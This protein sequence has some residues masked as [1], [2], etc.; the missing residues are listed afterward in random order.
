VL[1][2]ERE[3]SGRVFGATFPILHCSWTKRAYTHMGRTDLITKAKRG[4]KQLPNYH[5][6][7]LAIAEMGDHHNRRVYC[8][9]M[10]G[11]FE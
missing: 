5:V 4:L 6:A 8:C 7:R 2:V 3:P 9:D 10:V 1:T 11:V